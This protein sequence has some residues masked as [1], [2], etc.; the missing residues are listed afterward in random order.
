MATSTCHAEYIAAYEARLQALPIQDLIQEIMAPISTCSLLTPLL[1]GQHGGNLI[2]QQGYTN[3]SKPPFSNQVL[4]ASRT[5]SGGQHYGQICQHQGAAG[6][7]ID[8]ASQT[9]HSGHFLYCSTASCYRMK[10]KGNVVPSR[11]QGLD[12]QKRF[13]IDTLCTVIQLHAI[14]RS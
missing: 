14:T 8:K 2:S 6:R 5:N 9:V 10:L 13:A 7:S 3:S 4:L 12:N 1:C 11:A